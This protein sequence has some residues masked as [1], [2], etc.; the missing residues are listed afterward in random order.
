M[1]YI[2]S[3]RKYFCCFLTA[4]VDKHRRAMVSSEGQVGVSPEFM[5]SKSMAHPFG[6]PLFY[7]P[8]S[9]TPS[10]QKHAPKKGFFEELWPA[11]FVQKLSGIFPYHVSPTG[12]F[13]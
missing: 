6:E 9:H 5:T 13:L 10:Q 12:K 4:E 2:N 3:I 7:P 11:F 8:T 1:V